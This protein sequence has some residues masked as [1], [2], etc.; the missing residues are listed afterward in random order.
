MKF[1]KV[2]NNLGVVCIVT[3]T[4]WT[5][6]L[7]SIEWPM[8]F[9]KSLALNMLDELTTTIATAK[10]HYLCLSMSTNISYIPSSLEDEMLKLFES[11]LSLSI[12][13]YKHLLHPIV[14]WGWSAKTIW[15]GSTKTIFHSTRTM[16]WRWSH[17]LQMR[18][19]FNLNEKWKREKMSE[20]CSH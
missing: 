8:P 1:V 2:L 13:V 14:T 19:S 10:T 17:D 4:S 18:K 9:S 16:V 11:T 5:P 20:R 3:N 12:H 15:F 7:E 6:T